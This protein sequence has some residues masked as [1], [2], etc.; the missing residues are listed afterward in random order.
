MAK[1]D[2]FS[3]S[4]NH[5]LAADKGQSAV[6]DNTSWSPVMGLTDCANWSATTDSS[7]QYTS[8]EQCGPGE[9]IFIFYAYYYGL[10]LFVTIIGVAG[11]TAVIR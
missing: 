8:L 7:K 10:M 2:F 9:Y 4:R 1:Q 6:V 11:N 3:S 5:N